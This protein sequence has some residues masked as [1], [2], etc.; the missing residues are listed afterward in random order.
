MAAEKSPSSEE[1]K[2][3]LK[4]VKTNKLTSDDQKILSEILGSAIKLRQLVEKSKVT[5]GG[6]KVL[7]SLPFGFDIV[8]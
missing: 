5:K 2:G 8:K 6:K 7:V 1:L 3:V 4:R